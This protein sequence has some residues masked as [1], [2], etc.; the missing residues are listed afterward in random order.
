MKR[1]DWRQCLSCNILNI[2]LLGMPKLKSLLSV[3]L[4]LV[5]GSIMAQTNDA[6]IV[7]TSATE[8][9]SFRLTDVPRV[10]YPDKQTFALSIGGQQVMTVPLNEGNIVKVTYGTYDGNDSELT[11]K[12]FTLVD[13]TSFTNLVERENVNI[14]YERTFNNTNWQPLYVP[15]SMTYDDWKDNFDVAA[16]NNFHQYDDDNDG[17]NEVTEL[18]VIKIANDEIGALLPN[19]PYM[20]KAKETGKYTIQLSDVTLYPNK[21][22]TITCSSVTTEY[23]FTGTYRD[24]RNLFTAGNY[25]M[26]GGSLC[27]VADDNVVLKPYRWYLSMKERDSQFEGNAEKVRPQ[28][29]NVVIYGEEDETGVL[30][31][32]SEPMMDGAYYDL[33]GRKMEAKDFSALPKGIYIYNNRKVVK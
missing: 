33:S 4:L 22:N 21:V 10:T 18:E 12:D 3:I 13:G 7:W 6:I 2:Y 28:S 32:T 29:I 23:E 9:R 27:T 17:V 19:H 8:Y 26:A 16:I 30:N 11:G 24:V 15:F 31:H 14:S 20:I 1:S 5:T 25:V